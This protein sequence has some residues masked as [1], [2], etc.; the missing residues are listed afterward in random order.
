M[1]NDVRNHLRRA[2]FWLMTYAAGVASF[3]LWYLNQDYVNRHVGDREIVT[4]GCLVITIIASLYIVFG[5]P[6]RQRNIFAYIVA[7]TSGVVA[8][9]GLHWSAVGFYVSVLSGF[10]LLI[11]LYS[12]TLFVRVLDAWIN[13]RRRFYA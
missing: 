1:N 2:F 6:T 7:F 8:A 13:V 9:P 11:L 3:G 12:G 4:A 10:L 5:T